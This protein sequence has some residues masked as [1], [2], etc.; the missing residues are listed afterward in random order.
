MPTRNTTTQL[1]DSQG[2]NR[3]ATH[4]STN[5]IIKVENNVVGCIQSLNISESRPVK[6]LAEVGA[7][8]FFDSAPNG[9]S[10]TTGRVQRVRYDKTRMFEAFGRGFIHIHSQR[11]PFDIEIHDVFHDADPSNAIITTLKN[12]WFKSISYDYTV[13]DYIIQENADFE[14]ER[15]YSIINNKNVAQAVANGRSNPII[16][17]AFEQEADRGAFT[18]ALDAAGLLNAFISDP[19]N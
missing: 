3:T 13:S 18:G 17:N 16:L 19:R 12:V 6:F 4:L 15:I 7:D 2:N 8:G 9:P 10:T 11:I 1:T 14:C 5:I